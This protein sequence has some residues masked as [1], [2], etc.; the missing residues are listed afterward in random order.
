MA[1]A[2]M[3]LC[4]ALS[5]VAAELTDDVD[6]S[7]N[8]VQMKLSPKE[9]GVVDVLR[10]LTGSPNAVGAN[11]LLLEGFGIPSHYVPNRRVNEKLESLDEYK[12]RPVLRFSYDCEGPNIEGLHVTRIME[13]LPDEASMRVTWMVENKSADEQWLS[14]WVRNDLKPGGMRGTEDHIT[15]ASLDGMVSANRTGWYP[16]SRNWIASTDSTTT[17]TVY[18][19]FHADQTHSFLTLWDEE[20]AGRGFQAAFV[21]VMLKPGG[22]WKTVYRVG[23]VR[24]LKRVDFA[25]DELA[26]QL[27]AA[28]GQLVALLAAVKPLKGIRID[29]RVVAENGRVF[30]LPAKQFDIEPGKVIRCTYPFDAPAVGYYDYLAQFTQ[31]TATFPLGADTGSPHGG[32]DARF[33]VGKPV[34]RA[35]ESWTDA[36]HELDRGPR[37]LKRTLAF[38]GDAD[39]WIEPSLE[40]VFSED[41]VEA[42]GAANP[43]VK[44]GLARGEREAFQVCF[45]P[46]KQPMISATLQLADLVHA[47]GAARIT[48]ADV[49]LNDVRYLPVR[50]PSHFEGPTGLWPD[51]LPPHKPFVADPGMITTLWV[52]VHAKPGLPG[53]VYC[54]TWQIVADGEKPRPL[55]VEVRVYDFDLPATPRLKTDF[56]FWD[57]AAARGA[58]IKGGALAKAYLNNALEHRVTLREPLMINGPEADTAALKDALGRGATQIAVSPDLRNEPEKLK[59]V[60]AMVARAGLKG[61]VFTPFAYE[62]MEPGWP[63]LLEAVNQWKAGAPD[64]PVSIS[65]IG[66]RPFLPDAS[67]LWCIHAQILDTPNGMDIL[68][69]IGGGREVW[70]YVSNTPP[71]PY[72]NFFV[73]FAGIE[74]RILFWQ[75]WALGIRGMQY[76]NVDYIP[77]WQN[78]EKDLLDST[79]VNGDGV[80][81]YPGPEGPVN[82]IRWE[83][84]RD[85]VEDYD[86]LSLFMDRRNKL[87][88]Q[89]GQEALLSRAAEVFNLEKVVPSLV[90]FTR[91]N[92][93]LL[94]K[95]AEIAAMI[96]EMDRAQKPGAKKTAAPAVP[97]PALPKP[98]PL[99]KPATAAPAE[100]APLPPMPQFPQIGGRGKNFG[101][102][103]K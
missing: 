20:G 24:G 26:V 52:T 83:I 103:K 3:L 7:G 44:L 79:P 2:A 22:T 71:R 49:T 66:I 101:A 39:I 8:Y 38:T 94:Q 100:P 42:V 10:L 11:G 75:A 86:Y 78:P 9:G 56:G 35:M 93:L 91:D 21:P 31:G 4:A 33:A 80:L 74:H 16:A 46:A 59:A 84:I 73:D 72:G 30:K 12:D 62:P 23:I 98:E 60:N 82:S 95:R 90:T 32:I 17:E 65:T 27:D 96:E 99:P 68:K 5:A 18:S 63:K 53:G 48:P 88:E 61:R 92:Q 36:P 13:P 64:I 47:D 51:E 76:W 67:D 6:I 81:V 40:K 19:V 29:A 57:E 25:T 85:G 97:S 70:W 55:A 58:K 50:I 102:G 37:T 34:P 41:K 43:S 14:P 89:G 28:D 87:L 45:R 54:G 77:A 69:R 1:A 15:F